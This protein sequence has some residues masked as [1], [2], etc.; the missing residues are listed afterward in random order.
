MFI[1]SLDNEFGIAYREPADEEKLKI[2][3]KNNISKFKAYL[4]IGSWN[5]TTGSKKTGQTWN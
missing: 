3:Q 4:A 1:K 2:N 5:V